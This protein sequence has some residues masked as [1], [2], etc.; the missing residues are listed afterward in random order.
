MIRTRALE[1]LF[2]SVEIAERLGSRD[3]SLWF[4]D[5]SNYPGTPNI[6]QRKKWFDE[7]LQ[8]DTRKL[9]PGNNVCWSNTSR[10]SLPFIT[11]I[12][13]TG[14]WPFLPRSAGPQAKVL[15]EPATTM[16]AQNIEQIVAWLLK[17]MLGG[18]HFNDRRYADDDLTIGSID[19]YQVF[20]IFHEIAHFECETGTT[21]GHRLHDRSE[22][23]H[24]RQ[25]GG[26]G[27]DGDDG[28]GAI[29]ESR[30]GGP[31]APGGKPEQGGCGWRGRMPARC[32]RHRRASND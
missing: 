28:P 7:G 19:P 13:P 29:Y 32:F 3:I 11:P 17:E 20:R 24:E 16:P 5:G 30:A 21:A 27:A 1:H 26:D 9:E 25:D 23:Q 12:S 10:S 31:Q 14:A 15:V 6:R 18:F 4:A 22:P 2:D 8:A